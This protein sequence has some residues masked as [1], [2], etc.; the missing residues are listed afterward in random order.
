MENEN[1]KN[2]V[3]V[4]IVCITYNHRKVIEQAI[5]GFLKQK[6]SFKYKIIIHDDCSTDGTIE[7]I[8]KYERKYPDLFDVI[9]ESENMYSK[10]IDVLDI[11][12]SH[13]EGKY[14]AI[15]EGDD[16]WIDENKLQ[17]QVDFMEKNSDVSLCVHS[18]EEVMWAKSEKHIIPLKQNKSRFYSI[19][20][21]I[22]VGG[23]YFPTCSFLLR[24]S[25]GVYTSLK[26]EDGICGDYAILLYAGMKGKIY[27]MS[28][29]MSR[30]NTFYPGSW[31]D[32]HKENDILKS[33]LL[34]EITALTKFNETTGFVYSKYIM[35]RIIIIK[36]RIDCD[37]DGNYKKLFT[38]KEYFK[39]YKHYY[40]LKK[41]LSTFM[42]A[43]MPNVF[44][45]LHKLI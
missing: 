19:K 35:E 30:K 28:D 6:T 12:F 18:A 25:V 37:I 36:C 7:V 21:A 41:K 16:C 17:K 14:Y 26:W 5:K 32:R 3:M 44:S 34:K 23:A 2:D 40:P 27:Y 45:Y 43:Y 38:D 1:M 9:Y 15:C 22:L 29:I 8:Q 11:S 39:I 13:I 33:H 20:D 10:G 24:T 4:S 31:A 42:R